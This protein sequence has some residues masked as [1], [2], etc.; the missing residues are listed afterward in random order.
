MKKAL[1]TQQIALELT[2]IE[3]GPQQLNATRANEAV[4]GIKDLLKGPRGLE[5]LRGLLAGALLIV[6][7]GCTAAQIQKAADAL[8]AMEKGVCDQAPIAVVAAKVAQ[9][10]TVALRDARPG[11]DADKAVASANLTLSLT[12][13]TKAYC[14]AKGY[15]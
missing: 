2:K 5:I 1:T 3:D 9:A 15:K 10:G 4:K 14:I 12:E 7:S 13:Q 11:E 8:S 6:L